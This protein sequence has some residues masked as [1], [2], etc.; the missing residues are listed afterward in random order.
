MAA[1]PGAGS[2]AAPEMKTRP[3]GT[4][5]RNPLRRRLPCTPLLSLPTPKNRRAILAPKGNRDRPPAFLIH[6]HA[7][8]FAAFTARISSKIRKNTRLAQQTSAA[9]SLTSMATTTRGALQPTG[10]EAP[11]LQSATITATL[12]ALFPFPHRSLSKFAW[13]VG[14][15]GYGISVGI[16][17]RT[18]HMYCEV[19]H[20][21]EG[22]P[23]WCNLFNCA[24]NSRHCSFGFDTD[25]FC[26]FQRP[27]L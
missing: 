1:L 3:P 20:C 17:V 27:P 2:A 7:P 9:A 13:L 24:L 6:W 21:C 11:L 8:L 25:E 23:V 22:T 10:H 14:H 4:R 26:H 18:V 16:C 19:S 12:Q 15:V 5:S